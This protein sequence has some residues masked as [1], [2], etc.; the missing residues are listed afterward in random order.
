MGVG[1][2]SG[3][4][5]GRGPWTGGAAWLADC[6]LLGLFP[7]MHSLLLTP[8]GRR[9]LRRTMGTPPEL[10]TTLFAAASSALLALVF[11][12][13][14]PLPGPVLI[15]QGATGE[16][17]WAAFGAGWVLL[18][19]S[20][21]EAGLSVQTGA[22]GWL[23]RLRGAPPRYPPSPTRGLHRL[24]RHPIYL[25]FTLILWSGAHWTLDKLVLALLWTAYCVVGSRWKER[26]HARRTA[27]V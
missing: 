3:M 16:L 2:A 25:S 11:L 9:A 27:G 7:G 23:S 14:S 13:W 20:M 17:T 19:I 5:I 4:R 12:L 26:R 6:A 10:D 15:L 24:V 1:L 21:T 22:L 18:G 8:K